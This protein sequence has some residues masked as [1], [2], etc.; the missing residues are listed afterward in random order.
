MPVWSLTPTR[1]RASTPSPRAWAL[2]ERTPR[3]PAAGLAERR[4][5]GEP[6]SPC[7]GR[8][9]EAIHHRLKPPYPA[10]RWTSR[11]PRAG[12]A[13]RGEDATEIGKAL[14]RAINVNAR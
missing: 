10:P 14:A 12:D 13:P 2:R 7:K 6:C 4:E 8:R 5:I 11:H 9:P 1:A 3:E